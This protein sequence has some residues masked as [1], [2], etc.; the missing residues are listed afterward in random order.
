MLVLTI[1][2]EE[3]VIVKTDQPAEVTVRHLGTV[4]MPKDKVK[5]GFVAPPHVSIVRE[6]AKQKDGQQ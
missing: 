3:K 5:L 1:R 6:N 2:P 4:G